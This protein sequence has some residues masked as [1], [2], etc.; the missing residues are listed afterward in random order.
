M[1]KIWIDRIMDR[2]FSESFCKFVV[3]ARIKEK[4]EWAYK[5][6][7]FDTRNEMQ[8]VQEGRII[9]YKY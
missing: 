4:E 9:Y 5:R 7:F 1:R 8:Q 2:Y 3:V 6:L